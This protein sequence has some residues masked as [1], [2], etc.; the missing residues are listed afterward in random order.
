MKSNSITNAV[1][2]LQ[3]GNI[4]LYPTDTVYGLGVDAFNAEAVAAL[5]SLKGRTEDKH[6]LV[7]VPDIETIEKY[8]VLHEAARNLAE[9]FLPGPLTLVLPVKDSVPSFLAHDG[10]LGFRIPDNEF[11]LEVA[12]ALGRPYITTSANR[13]GMQTAQSVQAI[14][15]QFGEQASEISLVVDEGEMVAGKPSAIV[16]FTSETPELIREGSLSRE[17]LGL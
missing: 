4:I 1:F 14:L 12:R 5:Q 3:K 17:I 16:R 2:Q 9:R 6:F 8:A 13:S 11:C 10:T 7:I 15:E